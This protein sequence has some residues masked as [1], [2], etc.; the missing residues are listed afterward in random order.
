MKKKTV[1]E[2]LDELRGSLNRILNQYEVSDLMKWIIA[3]REEDLFNFEKDI[4]KETDYYKNETA[5]Y[6][7][8]KIDARKR[9]KLLKKKK[10]EHQTVL[11]KLN[12]LFKI[13]QK[14]D[15]E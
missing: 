14:L 4:Q 5:S 11:L 9:V 12:Q 8:Q 6:R 15:K 3:S 2:E 1:K 10:K 13:I 7:L